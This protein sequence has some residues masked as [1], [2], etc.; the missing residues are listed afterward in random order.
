MN[1]NYD[2]IRKYIEGAVSEEMRF[3]ISDFALLWNK[4]EGKLFDEYYTYPKVLEMLNNRF[5]F[6]N[7]SYIKITELYRRLLNYFKSRHI[8]YNCDSL[9]G[10]YH[11]REK[12]DILKDDLSILIDDSSPKG[13]LRLILLIVGR[14]RNNMFHGIKG[15]NDL[16]NQ[17]E[18]FNICNET[19]SLVLEKTNNLPL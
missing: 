4:Y 3:I 13:K 14:V 15:I 12:K 8:K 7:D 17:K 11:I 19:L 6:N 18:L 1:D 16:D 10:H 5:N 2:Q 9:I